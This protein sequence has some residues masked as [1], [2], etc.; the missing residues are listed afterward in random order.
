MATAICELRPA[1]ARL[2]QTQPMRADVGDVGTADPT[3]AQQR[4]L[5][6]LSSGAWAADPLALLTDRPFGSST[7][8]DPFCRRSGTLSLTTIEPWA[9]EPSPAWYA[10]MALRPPLGGNRSFQAQLRALPTDDGLRLQAQHSMPLLATMVAVAERCREADARCRAASSDCGCTNVGLD[11][12]SNA[13]G[14]R[15]LLRGIGVKPAAEAGSSRRPPRL[16]VVARSHDARPR[17][18]LARSELTTL[19]ARLDALRADLASAACSAGRRRGQPAAKRRLRR[20]GERRGRFAVAVEP[21]TAGG[22]AASRS[23]SIGAAPRRRRRRPRAPPRA[24]RRCRRA[25]STILR[26][27]RVSA[28]CWPPA[29]NSMPPARNS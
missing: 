5:T 9:L 23:G 10:R 6:L 27:R 18:R 24:A 8:A 17:A 7:S 21:G 12:F 4:H 11:A 14:V 1:Q 2:A 3:R 20:R 13:S 25:C 26:A 15:S 22:R 29:P 19:G 16:P 28:C